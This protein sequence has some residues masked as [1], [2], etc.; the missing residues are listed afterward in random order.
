MASTQKRFAS[1]SG[2]KSELHVLGWSEGS[3]FGI[4]ITE[5]E[6]GRRVTS[7]W[8]SG[9]SLADHIV[10]N[11]GQNYDLGWTETDVHSD[12]PRRRKLQ[13]RGSNGAYICQFC[14]YQGT[15]CPDAESPDAEFNLTARVQGNIVTSLP[16]SVKCDAF[17]L[18]CC[19]TPVLPFLFHHPRAVWVFFCAGSASSDKRP[20][21]RGKGRGST[22][23]TLERSAWYLAGREISSPDLKPP[24][25]PD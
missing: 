15:R 6:N 14:P 10:G 22:I 23:P 21:A 20:L 13:F 3:W 24:K 18:F 17:P 5:S 2:S 12:L 16:Y 19:A 1:K 8:Y 25:R 4:E 7:P 11:T 9:V